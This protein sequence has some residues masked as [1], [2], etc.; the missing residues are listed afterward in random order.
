MSKRVVVSVGRSLL[1]GRG[2]V[3]SEDRTVAKPSVSL[4]SIV[5]L[6]HLSGRGPNMMGGAPSM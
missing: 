1:L 3:G 5:L 4:L 6:I 2:N